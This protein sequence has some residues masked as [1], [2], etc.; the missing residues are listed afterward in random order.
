MGCHELARGAITD[1]AQPLGRRQCLRPRLSGLRGVIPRLSGL[2]LQQRDLGRMIEV[3][4]QRHLKQ[5]TISDEAALT[6]QASQELG[7]T[8]S[9]PLIPR[10]IR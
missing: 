5:V 10:P 2:L 7:Q 4:I 8:I 9:L 6:S 3:I 1:A